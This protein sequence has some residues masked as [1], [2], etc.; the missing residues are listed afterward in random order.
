MVVALFAGFR[1]YADL[2]RDEDPPFTIKTMIVRA[3]WPGAD[4]EQTAKQLTERLEKPLESLEYLDFVTSYTKPG[5][6]TVMI[7]L[8]DSTPPSA[9]PGQWYQ[10]RK[11]L[12]DI[13]GQL[14]QG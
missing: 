6:A 1:A 14:P 3:V 13:R 2:G 8:R 7:N 5:E 10:I 4:A 12:G 9:V 11:K